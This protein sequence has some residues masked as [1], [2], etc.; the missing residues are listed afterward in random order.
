MRYSAL[1]TVLI[2]LSAL[3]TSSWSKGRFVRALGRAIASVV[4]LLL[5]TSCSAGRQACEVS[6]SSTSE[7]TKS[8]A[9]L[10]DT[11]SEEL[12]VDRDSVAV[13]V[14]DTITITKTVTV[15]RNDKGDTLRIATETD[16]YRG[17]DARKLRV[18]SEKE[19]VV[20]DTVYIEHRDSVFVSNTNLTNKKKR[21]AGFR[22]TLKWIFAVVCAMTGL[23]ITARVCWR[24]AS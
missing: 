21:G 24:R 23:I 14:R 8:S 13:V 2:G 20:R 10:Q 17:H 9:K 3:C 6:S 19:K 12:I 16:R 15:D 11:R 18:K 7:A 22:A 1:A 4:L 5:M